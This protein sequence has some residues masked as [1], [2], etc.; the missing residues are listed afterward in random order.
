M[1]FVT[2]V[3]EAE[4][5]YILEFPPE[6]MERLGWRIGDTLSMAVEN[7]TIICRRVDVREDFDDVEEER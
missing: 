5:D 6:L 1:K 2:K 7:G 4:D 3:L